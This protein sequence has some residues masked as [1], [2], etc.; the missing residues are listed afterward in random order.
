VAAHQAVLS[1]WVSQGPQVAAFEREFAALGGCAP[2]LRVS[3]CTTALHLALRVGPC[4][5][6]SEPFIHRNRQQHPILWRN[7]GFRRY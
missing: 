1:G 3:N 4:D 5:E 7:S 2:C 6:V